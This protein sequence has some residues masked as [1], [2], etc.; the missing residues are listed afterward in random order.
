LIG[1]SRANT[2]TRLNPTQLTRAINDLRLR[3]LLTLE[4]LHDIL[5]RNPTH[6][7]VTLLK[8]HL[9]HAQPEPT[10]SVIE[11]RFLPL[12]RKHGL[13][14]PQ[15][16]FTSPVT[17]STPTSPTMLWSSSSTGGAHTAPETRS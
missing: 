16:N 1:G 12:L 15:I 17:A 13:P 11:D 10:R 8:P 6:P 2:A 14:T 5:D 9:E 4:Q 7:A 3:N